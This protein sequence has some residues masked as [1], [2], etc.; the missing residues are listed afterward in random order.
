MKSFSQRTKEMLARLEIGDDCCCE[1][2]MMGILMFAGKF[3]GL[4]IRVSLESL[5]AIERLAALV[6]RCLD[7][8]VQIKSLRSSYFCVLS[9]KK[10]LHKILEY[11]KLKSGFSQKLIKNEC[12]SAAFLR[13]SFLGGGTM[14]DPNKNYNMEFTVYSP[15]IHNEFKKLLENMGLGFRSIEKRNGFVLYTKN[16]DII[17]DALA[18]MGAFSAQME[19]L[20]VKIEKEV[21]SDITR[22][23]NGETAN[24]DKVME[25]SS[26]HIRAIDDIEKIMGIDN[27][28]D[29]LKEVAHLR[30]DH[31]DLSLEQLGK[32]LVPPLSKSGVNHRLRRILEIAENL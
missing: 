12:C 28:P 29:D 21:R 30:R 32:K 23:S 15:Q 26:R 31:K 16:S 9:D 27:L 14:T 19:I 13:G 20:N 17:C 1:A 4:E 8:D 22:T 3:K 6:K 18:H 11:E 7:V 5:D 10:V 2:E 24:M 25:A